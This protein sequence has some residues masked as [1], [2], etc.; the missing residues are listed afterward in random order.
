MEIITQQQKDI[1]LFIAI[2]KNIDATCFNWLIT[3]E[4]SKVIKNLTYQIQTYNHHEKMIELFCRLDV[5]Q[6]LTI[7]CNRY[8]LS[9]P[10]RFARM[11]ILQNTK[12]LVCRI[13]GNNF[14]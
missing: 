6:N 9:L 13:V 14:D 11:P 12:V 1:T 5:A 10:N 8:L 7:D 2:D 4:Q 3:Q